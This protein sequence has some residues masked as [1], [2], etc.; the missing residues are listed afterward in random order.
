MMQRL[1]FLVFSL[2][3]MISTLVS[4]LGQAAAE[5]VAG[6]TARARGII[7]QRHRRFAADLDHVSYLW[8]VPYARKLSHIALR[9]DAF[10]WWAEAD[11]RYARGQRP[12][13]GSILAFRSISRMPLG[14]L[15]VVVRVINSREILVN[16]ANWVPDTVTREVPVIDVSPDNTWTEVRQSTGADHF[17]LSYPTYGF[18]YDQAPRT[19]I[20]GRNPDTEVAEAPALPAL[21]VD[22]PNRALK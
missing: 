13:I 10:L 5:S 22:A 4:T 17:G 7:R 11:G 6:Q 21:R 8:C 18:I 16:E 14:H 9:G 19:I 20:A 2:I 12:V 15:A 3:F 1:L